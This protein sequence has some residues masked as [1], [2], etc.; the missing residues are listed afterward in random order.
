M[1]TGRKGRERHHQTCLLVCV[2]AEEGIRRI[3]GCKTFVTAIQSILCP[4]WEEGV[5]FSW[6]EW[7]GKRGQHQ[8]GRRRRRRVKFFLVKFGSQEW[9]GDGVPI[10]N[11]HQQNASCR[12]TLE[13]FFKKAKSHAWF[14]SLNVE[15]TYQMKVLLRR[16]VWKGPLLVYSNLLLV[17][18]WKRDPPPRYEKRRKKREQRNLTGGE[19]EKKSNVMYGTHTVVLYSMCVLLQLWK[20]GKKLA[21]MLELTCSVCAVPTVV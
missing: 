20:K 17:R 1:H 16:S 13:D 18:Y 5:A 9:A 11:G 10:T 7:E 2:C 8:D 19:G 3:F 14:R 21:S 4:R 15:P 6:W 12:F